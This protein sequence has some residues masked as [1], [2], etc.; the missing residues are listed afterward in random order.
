LFF[1]AWC[2]GGCLTSF[3]FRKKGGFIMNNNPT[4][5]EEQY[6][7]GKK[8]EEGD[9]VAK[10][11]ERAKYW[12]TKAAEQGSII[13]E[14]ALGACMVNEEQAMKTRKGAGNEASE[15]LVGDAM[16]QLSNN[17]Y[18][19]AATLFEQAAKLGH[20][21][22]QFALGDAYVNEKGVG[23][24]Y[25]T[26]AS[27]FA[28]AAE[29]GHPWAQRSLGAHL[30]YGMGVPK[31]EKKAIYWFSK[32]AEQGDKKA[33]ETLDNFDSAAAQRVRKELI[34]QSR[35]ERDAIRELGVGETDSKNKKKSDALEYLNRGIEYS[36]KYDIDNAIAEFTEA[37][38]LDPDMADAYGY[39]A[40]MY[41][42]KNDYDKAIADLSEVIR[43]DTNM[44]SIVTAYRARGKAHSE[45]GN[46]QEAI[47]DYERFLK[48]D[49]NNKDAKFI[50]DKIKYIR[51]LKGLNT[52]KSPRKN[53][54][55]YVATCVYGSY[56]CPEVW[57]LRRYRDGYLSNSWLGRLFIRIYYAVSPKIVE[58]IGDRK[59]FNRLCKPVI[60]SIV[61]TLHNNGVDSSPYLDM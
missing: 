52:N 38:Q 44:S 26:A 40:N 29:Q 20:M 1:P 7:L 37:I 60:D 48:L 45:L 12:Y 19:E 5:A 59:W 25:A 49:P 8:Y 41:L 51:P 32:A 57:T 34:S 42:G 17:N 50:R 43:L 15:R 16:K 55:C 10:N 33:L 28:K 39:R 54:G 13:A 61:R 53:G 58:S 9:G 14:F 31:D 2:R 6:E 23:K 30:Y 4:N 46:V 3:L 11:F 18:T 22:A 27:W 47:N 35:N 36:K 21:G 56:D 24:N